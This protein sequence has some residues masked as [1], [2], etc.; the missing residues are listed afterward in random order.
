MTFVAIPGLDDAANKHDKSRHYSRDPIE[1]GYCLNR[2]CFV[3]SN[4]VWNLVFSQHPRLGNLP[5][6]V[7]IVDTMDSYGSRAQPN[8]HTSRC[9]LLAHFLSNN[10]Q[11]P[12]IIKLNF[13]F[14]K[15]LDLHR[16]LALH[17]IKL[18]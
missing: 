3:P 18:C 1:L 16:F 12:G 17:T 8:Y 4:L 9:K 6:I 5:L 7:Y 15:A 14:K 2:D 13:H 11:S 10:I